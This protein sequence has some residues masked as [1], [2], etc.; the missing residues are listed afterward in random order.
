MSLN[1]GSTVEQ[2]YK[3]LL[4]IGH[5]YNL[6]MDESDY[7]RFEKIHA[8]L[9]YAYNGNYSLNDVMSNVGFLILDKLNPYSHIVGLFLNFLFYD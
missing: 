6:E 2:V 3:E 7:Y 8:V 4:I 1:L 9:T 5:V